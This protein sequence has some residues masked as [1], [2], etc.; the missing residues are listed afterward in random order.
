MAERKRIT[1]TPAKTASKKAAPKSGKSNSNTKRELTGIVITLI[2]ILSTLSFCVDTVFFEGLR[3]IYRG[4]FSYVGYLVPLYITFLGIHITVRRNV[5]SH[6]S[7]YILTAILLIVFSAFFHLFAAGS[8]AF[9]DF[10]LDGKEGIGGG[11]FGGALETPI[12]TLFGDVGAFFV[13]LVLLAVCIILLTHFS[14]SDFASNMAAKYREKRAAKKA[15]KQEG[16]KPAEKEKKEPKSKAHIENNIDFNPEDIKIITP[17]PIDTYIPPVLPDKDDT[18]AFEEIPFDE[19]SG[20]K[21]EKEDMTPVSEEEI[22]KEIAEAKPVIK[23]NFPSSDLLDKAKPS[24]QKSGSMEDLRELAKKLVETLKSFGVEAKVLEVTQGPSVTRFE[25]QP[26][27]GV[28]VSKIVNLADDIALNLAAFGVRI[29]A[30]I[31]G[32]AAIGIEIPNQSVSMVSLREMIESAEFTTHSS[33]TAIALGRDIYGKPVVADIRKMP[34][35]LIAGATG[36]GKSV[37]INTIIASIVY[38]SSPSDVKFLMIDPKV[39]E[40][41]VYNGIP[42]LIIPVVTDAR[43]AA[44][45]LNWAVSEMA[46]RYKLFAD[47][48][49]RNITGYNEYAESEGLDKMEH[50]VIIIDELADLMMVSPR[51]VEDAVCRLAQLARAAGMHLVMATQRPSVDVVTG[52][53]K[54]NVPSRISFAVSSAVDSRT[55]LDMMGAEK[56]LGKGDMLYLPFGASKP[57]R[58]QGAFVSDH[59]I[60]RLVDYIKKDYEADYDEEVLEKIERGDKEEPDD[61]GDKDDLLNQ[62]IEIVVELGQASTSLIQ[63]KLKVGY[64]RA[65]RIVDQMEARGIVGPPEGS[66]PRNVL[67]SKQ[68]WY[69]MNMNSEE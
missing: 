38:K 12:K 47:Y 39:V 5:K 17:E 60:E 42:H 21:E 66:K 2:G 41:G 57:T 27:A 36:A 13:L 69:E 44:G 40:L 23:Y 50:I 58:I 65:G 31:P 15:D 46:R 16:A 35:L 4:L 30:P 19:A 56:L 10:Y 48:D 63:R 9:A 1:K 14:I 62:A 68:Q 26:S 51:E 6:I 54:A 55:I 7:K 29:E 49:V 22:A 8:Q 45:A 59:E 24:A 3:S 32:K 67:I 52:L 20:E 53:I 64:A 18:E 28:K 61:P 33:P 37:C 25:L 43:K 11:I 34:H